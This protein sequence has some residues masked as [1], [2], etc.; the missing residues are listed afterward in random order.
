MTRT[1]PSRPWGTCSTCQTTTGVPLIACSINCCHHIARVALDFC[2]VAVVFF[3]HQ[4]AAPLSSQVPEADI[5]AA[6]LR[7]RVP[8]A[9]QDV[10]LPDSALFWGFIIWH[11]RARR[12]VIDEMQYLDC[13]STSLRSEVQTSASTP[14]VICTNS[15]GSNHGSRVGHGHEQPRTTRSCA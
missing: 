6:L 5:L 12:A 7:G 4:H 8:G 2:C 10:V 11:Q 13:R 9:Q 3:P 15:F 1:P 14:S